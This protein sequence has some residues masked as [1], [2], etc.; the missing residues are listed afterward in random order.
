MISVI[1]PV[2]NSEQ[3]LTKCLES[4]VR[5]TYKDFE[6]I[7]VDDGSTDLSLSICLD[8]EN[9]DSRF[10]VFQKENGGVSSARNYG[11]QHSRSEFIYM[12][13][14]D[15]ELYDDALGYLASKM[16]SQIDLVFAGFTM[17]NIDGKQVYTT[18]QGHDFLVNAKEAMD[19]VACPSKYY[20]TLGMPWLNLFRKSVI[21]KGC[22]KFDERYSIAEDR[23]FL[24]SYISN[25]SN[26]IRF[27][28]KPIYKYYLRPSGIMNT[29]YQVFQERTLKILDLYI[30]ILKVV[31][32]YAKSKKMVFQTKLTIYTK[33][34]ELCLYVNQ[35][36]H[37]EMC[38]GLYNKMA[39]C[40]TPHDLWMLKCRDRLKQLIKYLHS[41]S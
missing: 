38:Q 1:I 37:S 33:Y 19:I 35:F 23:L 16:T 5:Q 36:G 9:R 29:R 2:Y 31:N 6:C 39:S 7:I 11:I 25:C 13:D 3:Y 17:T 24:V 12:A 21:E 40:M 28:T 18:V 27:T 4:I 14:S 32:S 30:E 34:Q 10:R 22:L 26:C 15:D 41:N 8:F 20:K